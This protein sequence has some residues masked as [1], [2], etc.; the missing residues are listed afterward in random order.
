MKSTIGIVWVPTTSGARVSKVC[1]MGALTL[2]S[3]M[4]LPVNAV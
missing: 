2:T 3:N 1:S 4:S